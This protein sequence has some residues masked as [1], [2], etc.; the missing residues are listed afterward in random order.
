MP[1]SISCLVARTTLL[2]CG[3]GLRSCKLTAADFTYPISLT[4]A[5]V[6][7][8]HEV[9]SL[10]GGT[11]LSPSFGLS[12]IIPTPV[13]ASCRMLCPCS[14]LQPHGCTA[15]I[16]MICVA[17]TT[18]NGPIFI[19]WKV[20]STDVAMLP[21]LHEG[22]DSAFGAL[23]A[24]WLSTL[25]AR[26]LTRAGTQSHIDCACRRDQSLQVA[27]QHR[28]TSRGIPEAALSPG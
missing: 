7:H 8:T 5:L 9:L 19:V 10:W 24:P 23:A 26:L 12:S 13:L 15:H 6:L 1:A 27:S 22:H 18:M 25:P 3:C 16:G 20:C 11:Q 14:A 28:F 2:E 4:S 21:T 17:L